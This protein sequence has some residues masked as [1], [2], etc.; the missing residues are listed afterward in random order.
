ML[1]MILLSKAN[2]FANSPNAERGFLPFNSFCIGDAA[3]PSPGMKL[4]VS[5]DLIFDFFARR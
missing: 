4:Q 1:K 2:V 5:Q 3:I